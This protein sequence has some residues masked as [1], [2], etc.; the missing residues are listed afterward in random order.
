MKEVHRRLAGHKGRHE[1][2]LYP[3]EGRVVSTIYG[4]LCYGARFR[5]P[6]IRRLDQLT[7]ALGMTVDQLVVIATGLHRQHAETV[8][9]A[10]AA[11]MPADLFKQQVKEGLWRSP[12]SPSC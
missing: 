7:M 9:R 4:P 11:G 8:Q 12:T 2:S 5:D 1:S 10:E 6:G 3:Y